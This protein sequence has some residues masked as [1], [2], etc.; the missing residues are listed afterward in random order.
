[1]KLRTLLI[2]SFVLFV[3]LT[4]VTIAGMGQQRK[5]NARLMA[6]QPT[7]DEVVSIWVM[8]QEEKVARDV[9][10][11]LYEEWGV[12]YPVLQYE[13]GILRLDP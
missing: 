10:I 9:Y 6:I 2:I 5:G 1:M 8:I 4:S 13:S 7:D 3:G 12:F 11:T